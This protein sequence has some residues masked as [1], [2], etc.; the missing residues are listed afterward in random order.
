MSDIARARW[1]VGGVEPG[2]A[3]VRPCVNIR[4][5]NRNVS[6]RAQARQHWCDP[7]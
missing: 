6:P 2:M 1:S 5:R 7:L 3:V 4:P